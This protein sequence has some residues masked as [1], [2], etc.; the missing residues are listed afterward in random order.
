MIFSIVAATMI[1]RSDCSSSDK[2][3]LITSFPLIR[4]TRTSDTGPLKGISDTANAAEAAKQA[5]AS[6]RVFLSPEI[7]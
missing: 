2:D 1:S 3:G 4:A 6:G 5:N 7:K